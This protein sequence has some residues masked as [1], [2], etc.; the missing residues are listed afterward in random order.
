MAVN[1]ILS[2]NRACENEE[3]KKKEEEGNSHSAGQ[4]F[5]FWKCKIQALARCQIVAGADNILRRTT[6]TLP[7]LSTRSPSHRLMWGKINERRLWIR[8][9]HATVEPNVR[10]FVGGGILFWCSFRQALSSTSMFG[11]GGDDMTNEFIGS[12]FPT[13]HR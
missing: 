5:C 9:N 4:A 2:P 1:W 7:A 3:G 12:I 8:R 6:R 10:R 13:L 11:A